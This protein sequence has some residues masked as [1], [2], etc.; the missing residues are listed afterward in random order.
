MKIDILSKQNLVSESASKKTVANA[1]ILFG[2]KGASILKSLE[3]LSKAKPLSTPGLD[4]LIIL[5]SK[6][7]PHTFEKLSSTASGKNLVKAAK[8]LASAKTPASMLKAIKPFTKIPKIIDTV[9]YDL[10]YGN[11]NPPKKSLRKGQSYDSNGNVVGGKSNPLKATAQDKQKASHILNTT[12][13]LDVKGKDLNK[14]NPDVKK[15]LRI[16]ESAGVKY[17]ITDASGV[18]GGWPDF[19]IYGSLKQITDFVHGLTTEGVKRKL[20]ADEKFDANEYYLQFITRN[21]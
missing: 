14:S 3:E 11:P 12:L 2:S 20:T 16:M 19:A 9:K 17:E 10:M 7:E 15:M 1:K 6:R 5:L 18:S 8:A 4:M 21:K 13:T